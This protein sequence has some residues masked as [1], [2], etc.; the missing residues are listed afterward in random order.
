VPDLSDDLIAEQADRTGQDPRLLELERLAAELH[1]EGQD[2]TVERGRV[3]SSRDARDLDRAF[4]LPVKEH[5]KLALVSDTHGGS[6]FEQ[7]SALRDFYKRADEAEVDAFIHAGDWTQGPDRMHRDQ[8]LNVHAHGADA[9]SGY[10]IATYPKSERGIPTY[11]ITGNHDDSFLNEG[12]VNV[13]RRITRERSDIIYVGQDAAYMSL[14]S[15]SAYVIHPDG[16]GSYAKTYKS[17]KIAAALP[18]EKNVRLLIVGHYHSYSTTLERDAYLLQLPCFQSQYSWLAR[19]ALHPDVGG[20]ILDIDLDDN[21][22]LARFTHELIRYRPID[23]DWDRE[24]SS[25]MDRAWNSNG[26]SF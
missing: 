24:V 7:L 3:H 20:V 12:G 19:K 2:F 15:L 18:P 21:G 1:S 4:S 13:V 22:N 25:S 11:A 9:Q 5:L 17:Q 26:R 23:E 16:G 6:K 10:V 8:Y 14:G